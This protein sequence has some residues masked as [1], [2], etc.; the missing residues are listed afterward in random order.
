MLYITFKGSQAGEFTITWHIGEKLSAF[1]QDKL[2]KALK[3]EY[4]TPIEVQADG[5]ELD[6][7]QNNFINLP[8][9]R[10]CRVV[11]WKGDFAA[12]IFDHLPREH[13]GIKED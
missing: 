12:L 7:I 5:D 9:V 1:F 3:T 4:P 8:M 6:F 2:E 11:R 10:N 13:G